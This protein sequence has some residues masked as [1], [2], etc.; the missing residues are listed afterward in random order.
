MACKIRSVTVQIHAMFKVLGANNEKNIA[1]VSNI[2][3][4]SIKKGQDGPK[5]SISHWKCSIKKGTL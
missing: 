3:W 1:D 4:V 2:V 5:N